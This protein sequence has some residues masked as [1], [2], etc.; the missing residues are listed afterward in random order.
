VTDGATELTVYASLLVA[1]LAGSLHCIGMCG[2]IMFAFSHAF[3][4]AD[5]ARGKRSSLFHDFAF[6][7]AGRVWTYGFI[8][9]VVGLLGQGV[10]TSAWL[11]GWQRGA[12]LAFAASIVLCGLVLA[13]VVPAPRVDTVLGACGVGKLRGRAWFAGLVR[14]PG[15]IARLLLGAL[16][17]LLPCG[18]VYAALVL[19][20]TLP[21][22]GHAALGM[23]VFGLGTV[24]SLSAVLLVGRTAPAWLRVHGTRIVGVTLILIGCF[25]LARAWVVRPD[26]PCPGCASGYPISREVAISDP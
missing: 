4:E 2:P 13:G 11:A 6:Y 3:G 15:A 14:T 17:G 19:A 10:R 24:P 22:P 1:G 23:I 8:G 20:A 16:M 26:E 9:L 25:M 7:H 18:L 12:S 21:T 5:R